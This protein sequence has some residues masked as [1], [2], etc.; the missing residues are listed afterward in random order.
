MCAEK[1][2]TKETIA[3]G[4]CIL[5]LAFFERHFKRNL[6]EL[7][8]FVISIAFT[9]SEVLKRQFI[10]FFERP[11]KPKQPFLPH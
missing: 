5:L 1:R 11:K 6:P 2:Q 9:I 10:L 3:K 4:L 8:N 7:N